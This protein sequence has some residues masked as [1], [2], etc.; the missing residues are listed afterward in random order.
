[1]LLKKSILSEADI[2]IGFTADTISVMR[3]YGAVR[4]MTSIAKLRLTTKPKF[5]KSVTKAE[6]IPH[7]CG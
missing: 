2:V 6:P 5:K 7:L 3:L 4:D 1:M